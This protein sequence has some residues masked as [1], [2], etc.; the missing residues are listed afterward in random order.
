LHDLG[1]DRGNNPIA[2]SDEQFQ[3]FATRSISSAIRRGNSAWRTSTRN[4]LADYSVQ[5]KGS[6]PKKKQNRNTPENSAEN[7]LVKENLS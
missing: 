7:A 3:V 5:A 6:Y 2:K 4:A 1:K